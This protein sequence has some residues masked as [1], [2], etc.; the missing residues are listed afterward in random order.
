MLVLLV[1]SLILYFVNARKTVVYMYGPARRRYSDGDKCI[2]IFN[3]I[4]LLFALMAVVTNIFTVTTVATH[5]GYFQ[6]KAGPT[7]FIAIFPFLL[8]LVESFLHCTSCGKPQLETPLDLT[9]EESGLVRRKAIIG[10]R[11]QLE[12][13]G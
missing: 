11:W 8:L 12:R 10:R 4:T 7:F 6:V 9:G 2:R 1:V 13:L 5:S 3:L